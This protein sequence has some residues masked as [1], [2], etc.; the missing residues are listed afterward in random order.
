MDE[1]GLHCKHSSTIIKHVLKFVIISISL[2]LLEISVDL[3]V[4]NLWF[5]LPHGAVQLTPRVG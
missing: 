2:N 1:I 3:V 5:I 4:D